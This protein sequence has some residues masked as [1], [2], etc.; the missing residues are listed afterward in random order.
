MRALRSKIILARPNGP[1][2]GLGFGCGAFGGWV[3]GD[4][5]RGRGAS[6][7]EGS[8]RT[9]ARQSGARG[10]RAG[11]GPSAGGAPGRA[12]CPALAAVA[13]DAASMPGPYASRGIR[14][15]QPGR[16]RLAIVSWAPSGCTR[17]LFIS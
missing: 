2:R 7:G 1:G 12:S 14:R 9:G 15:I 17:S 6:R 5:S 13:C 4:G 11:A 10:L 8:G 3:S 16:M